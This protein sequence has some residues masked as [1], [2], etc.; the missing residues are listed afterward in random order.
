MKK[1]FVDVGAGGTQ[2]YEFPFK[3]EFDECILIEPHLVLS[4]ALQR[5]MYGNTHVKVLNQALV[6]S[7]TKDCL[8]KVS[9]PAVWSSL[10]VATGLLR[11]YP[12]FKIIREDSVDFLTV[13]SLASNLEN[14]ALSIQFDCCGAE[15]ELVRSLFLEVPNSCQ[16][17]RVRVLLGSGEA[18]FNE[19][20]TSSEI[21]EHM[22]SLHYECSELGGTLRKSLDFSFSKT[23]KQDADKVKQQSELDSLNEKVHALNTQTN[24]QTEK[25]R[26]LL[27]QNEASIRELESIHLSRSEAQDQVKVLKSELES[28]HLSRSEAQD[29]VKV[30]KS[31]LESA[32]LSRSEAQDQVK[33]LKDELESV[34]RTQAEESK[35]QETEAVLT[36]LAN[37]E[38]TLTKKVRQSSETTVKQVESYMGIREYLSTGEKGLSFHGWPIS[39]QVGLYLLGLIE[40]NDY[41]CVIEFGSGTSTV[42]FSDAMLKK[43]VRRESAIPNSA[44]VGYLKRS[45][46]EL[47]GTALLPSAHDL[48]RRVISFEHNKKYLEQTEQLLES[49]E[50]QHLVSLIYAPL[51]D[52]DI[53]GHNWLYYNCEKVLANL[54]EML[55]ETSRILVLIDGPPQQTGDKARFPALPLLIK[56]LGNHTFDILVDDYSRNAEKEIVKEWCAF[57]DKRSYQYTGEEIDAEKGA[58]HLRIN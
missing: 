28:A 3:G 15:L 9:R 42:M 1:V 14:C 29:Q 48:P 18:E 25:V 39:S 37:L 44:E 33:V 57:L 2:E 8:F 32:H 13:K 17:T 41:Q 58:F 50:L 56:H 24:E 49:R 31:E 53:E 43:A 35:S 45:P 34:R 27:V 47:T 55:N 20:A 30:L 52:H 51:T 12:N 19:S 22:R 11:R 16:I 6:S 21:I 10:Y 38:A 40:D 54:S 36:A 46:A 5:K 26:G 4:R 7:D 23:L